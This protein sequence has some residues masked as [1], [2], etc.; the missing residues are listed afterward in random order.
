MP[1]FVTSEEPGGL[2][3]GMLPRGAY[4]GALAS[5]Y[6]D[7]KAAIADMDKGA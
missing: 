3:L 5:A 1:Y 6:A 7:A 2:T 4:G